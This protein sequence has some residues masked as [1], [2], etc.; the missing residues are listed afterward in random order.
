MAIKTNIIILCFNSLAYTR[1]TIES[2][3]SKTF[4][5]YH[6]TII[7]NGS[8]L[9]TT[10]YLAK[11]KPKGLCSG[12][13]IISNPYNLG[14]GPAYN[15]G[16]KFS[17]EHG[18]KYSCLCNNDLFFSRD[19]LEIL[20]NH[21]DKNPNIAM[22]NPL[23]PSSRVKYSADISTKEKLVSI[24][25]T[26]DY[27]KELTDYMEMPISD[28]DEFCQK[29]ISNNQID[30]NLEIIKFPDSLSTCVCLVNNANMM[31]LGYVANNIFKKYGSEDID[32]CW[33]IIKLGFDCAIAHDVYVH[34]FRGKAL[35]D[36]NLDR[37]KLLNESN[38][39]LYDKWKKEIDTFLIEQTKKGVDVANRLSRDQGDEFWLLSQMNNSVN[40]MSSI[41]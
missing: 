8:K 2:L 32:A 38:V 35:T 3:F 12:I 27:Q 16:F 29:I 21:M 24:N 33:S 23:R 31:R 30:N 15:Q 4:N 20:E 25:D 28:F 10:N 17:V 40:L 11:L 7:D 22:I 39:I 26:L 6:L 37:R 9:A 18:F 13:K 14:V 36:N 5:R 19:W 1:T 41:L 34:H